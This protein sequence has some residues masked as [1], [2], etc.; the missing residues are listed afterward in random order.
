MIAEAASPGSLNGWLVID[1]P[2][3]ITSSR[4]VVQLR[5]ATGMKAGHAG[6]LDPLATG[7][8]PVAL[9]EATKTVGFISK[10]AKR[11]S[12]RV[13]WG[14]ATDTE[15]SEGAVIG[16]SPVRPDEAAIR[17][18]LPRFIGTIAQRPPAY[19]AIKIAGRRAYALARADQPPSLS[20]RPVEIARLRLLSMPDPDHAD[21]EAVVGKGTYIRALARDLA[22]ALGTLG[23]VAALRRLSVGPFTEAQAISLETADDRRHIVAACGH[24]LPIETALDG[25]PALALTAAEADRL[26]CGQR[27]KP[28]DPGGRAQLDRAGTGAV[29]SVWHDR[30]LIALARIEDGSVRPLRVINC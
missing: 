28:G 1:K 14:T 6:T 29:V 20:A 19:S 17:A 10:A 9:G 2:A 4:V 3:G 30:A 27:V 25:I 26:R 12:F 21:C 23:H 15:D 8:L 11:Y 16:E 18:V 7:I 5:R 22:A 24:L 13:R